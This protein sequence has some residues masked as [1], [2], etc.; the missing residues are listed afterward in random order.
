MNEDKNLD[1]DANSREFGR[2]VE[3]GLGSEDTKYWQ[4]GYE[5]GQQ[6]VDRDTKELVKKD[7]QDNSDHPL[8]LQ[9]TLQGHKGDA[10]DEKDNSAE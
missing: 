1:E 3:A 10:Q 4:A 6:L 8:F 9:D 2:G 7:I 5:L